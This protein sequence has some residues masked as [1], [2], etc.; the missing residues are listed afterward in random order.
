MTESL[1]DE[2]FVTRYIEQTLRGSGKEAAWLPQD[3]DFIHLITNNL[4]HNG[5]FS[6]VF[7]L[8]SMRAHSESFIHITHPYNSLPPISSPF[9][10]ISLNI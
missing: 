3:S 2:W 1:H 6:S 4:Q 5:T 9:P 7:R 10:F 8:D